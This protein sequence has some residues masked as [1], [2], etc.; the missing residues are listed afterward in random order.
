MNAKTESTR[1]T[2]FGLEVKV[3][4]RMEGWSLIL[5]RGRKFV[6]E[7]ANLRSSELSVWDRSRQTGHSSSATMFLSTT[8]ITSKPRWQKFTGN[9]QRGN[10]RG[11]RTDAHP[12]RLI[13]ATVLSSNGGAFCY[14]GRI[15]KRRTSCPANH[16]SGVGTFSKRVPRSRR[17]W[18]GSGVSRSWPALGESWAGIVNLGHSL[19]F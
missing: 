16:R 12:V 2:Y 8:G 14:Q 11:S 19:A 13:V 15:P 1:A 3:I 4:I 5:Y 17:A 7:T 9:T 10:K 18:P 6:V